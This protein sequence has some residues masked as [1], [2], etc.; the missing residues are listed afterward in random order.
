MKKIFKWIVIILVVLFIIGLVFG[1]DD[2]ETTGSSESASVA[3]VQ[4]PTIDTTA[5][6]IFNAYEKNEVAAD[7]EY[8]GRKIRV[9][10]TVSSID[11]GLGDGANVLLET[12]NQF[13]SV[14]ASG[15]DNFT[16]AAA[17]LS[18]GQQV[19][20]TCVGEGEIIGMPMLGDCVIE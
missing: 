11:S 1:T 18:K 17:Q 20:M 3:E 7:R 2:S 16:N 12:S 14:T 8:K 5:T 10:G 15:D 6:N 19:R 4:E 13:L 9:A